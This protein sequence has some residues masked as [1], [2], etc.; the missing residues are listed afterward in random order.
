MVE[1]NDAFRTEKNKFL[2]WRSV[3]AKKFM[4]LLELKM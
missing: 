2:G 3:T 1:T 4:Y